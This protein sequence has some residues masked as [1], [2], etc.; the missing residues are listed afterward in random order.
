MA[1]C[2]SNMYFGFP[3][4]TVFHLYISYTN[5]DSANHRYQVSGLMSRYLVAI[6]R[7][8]SPVA[9][10]IIFMASPRVMDCPGRKNPSLYPWRKL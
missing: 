6:E 1:V 7:A 2:P 10:K 8:G 5:A 3:F 4:P 9:R